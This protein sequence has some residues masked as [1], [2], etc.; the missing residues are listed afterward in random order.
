MRRVVYL[1]TLW[2]S[3]VGEQKNLH[4]GDS[5]KYHTYYESTEKNLL[6]LN[7]NNIKNTYQRENV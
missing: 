7:N 1:R 6:K 4:V 3:Y 5:Y 2:D